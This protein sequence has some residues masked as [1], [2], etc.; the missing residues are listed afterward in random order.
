MI[1]QGMQGKITSLHEYTVLSI[2]IN[3]YLPLLSLGRGWRHGAGP[4]RRPTPGVAH[5]R[6]WLL[7]GTVGGGQGQLR[8]DAGERLSNTTQSQ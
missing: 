2:L 6:R 3:Q 5:G 1:P 8:L 7:R 4:G